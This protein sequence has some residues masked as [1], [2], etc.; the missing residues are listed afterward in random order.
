MRQMCT[1]DLSLS[2]MF[3]GTVETIWSNIRRLVTKSWKHQ[4][5]NHSTLNMVFRDASSS[6][7][8]RAGE[9]EYLPWFSIQQM[10]KVHI[11]Q[12]FFSRSRP[13]EKKHY[14][15]EQ[16]ECL[17]KMFCYAEEGSP[18]CSFPADKT[19]ITAPLSFSNWLCFAARQP[20]QKKCFFS[21][22][23]WYCNIKV[24]AKFQK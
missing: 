3:N 24:R 16:S 14:T 10:V 23:F 20:S 13:R 4:L 17:S 1:F 8:G 22:N 6:K 7:S 12:F 18:L 15:I 9:S 11:T 5:I 2:L 21:S 19:P